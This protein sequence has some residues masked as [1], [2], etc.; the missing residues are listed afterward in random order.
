MYGTY[1][2]AD[3]V[4]AGISHSAT[5][6]GADEITLEL[7]EKTAKV[8]RIEQVEENVYRGIGPYDVQVYWIVFDPEGIQITA[9]AAADEDYQSRA[10]YYRQINIYNPETG[11]I[12]FE[13]NEE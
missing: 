5:F 3:N 2:R 7:D 12:I 13:I 1:M 6:D 8:A 10:G 4:E 9:L 11:E